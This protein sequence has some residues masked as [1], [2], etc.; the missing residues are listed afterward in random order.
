MNSVTTTGGTKRQR[1][2]AED[3]AHFCIDELMPRM[4]TLE[5]EIHLT[6]CQEEGGEACCYPLMQT[7]P[8]RDFR[9]DIDHRIYKPFAKK[10]AKSEYDDFVST[11][12]HEMVHA[13]QWA[14]G[15]LED[16]VTATAYGYKTLW[17]GKDYSFT[18][19]SRQPWERQAYRM[20]ESLLHKYKNDVKAWRKVS[21][22]KRV[23]V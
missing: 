20:Q 7:N 10:A 4:R 23:S 2:L 3:V 13:W 8:P 5:I 18:P 22:R 21:K 16:K 15:V 17:K 1:N 12:C 19:Y 9:I 11:I 14:T 6:K